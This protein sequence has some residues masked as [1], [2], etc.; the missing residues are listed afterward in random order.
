Y[1]LGVEEWFEQSN[2]VAMAQII[3]RM[4]EAVRKGYW[5][6]SDQTRREL[7]TRYQ[8][9]ASRHDVFTSNETF[10]AYVAGLAHGFGLDGAPSQAEASVE[11]QADPG[12]P[13][14]PVRGQAL[15]EVSDTAVEVAPVTLWAG[16]L[17]FL[18]ALGFVHRA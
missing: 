3:E 13:T 17:L 1:E 7:V 14:V 11:P 6:A 18:V 16:L 4:L 12:Q 8:E 15:R 9:I 2:P 10:K 5:D